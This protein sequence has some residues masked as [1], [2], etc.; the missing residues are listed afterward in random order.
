MLALGPKAQ[1]WLKTCEK[2]SLSELYESCDDLRFKLRLSKLKQS[3]HSFYIYIVCAAGRRKIMRGQIYEEM[4]QGLCKRN[5]PA[6]SN[7]NQEKSSCSNWHRIF[8]IIWIQ[9]RHIQLH[10]V[11]SK[12]E[13]R[14]YITYFVK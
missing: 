8:I 10:E 11:Y 4:D 7:Q 6:A 1:R 9:K 12:E 14:V 5:N 13:L 2:I 3:L